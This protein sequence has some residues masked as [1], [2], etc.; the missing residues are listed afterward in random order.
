LE[1]HELTEMNETK[2]RDRPCVLVVDDFEELRDVVV[3]FAALYGIDSE[4]AENGQTA[5]EK[6]KNGSFD[7]VLMDL[8]M[9]VMDGFAALRW[10]REQNFTKPIIAITAHVSAEDQE[11]C[12]QAGFDGFLAKPF[13][14]GELE[15]IFRNCS[16]AFFQ[17]KGGAFLANVQAV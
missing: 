12:V 17:S 15:R 10:M 5:C 4:V 7:L 16:D 6:L 9:P 2:N 11:K 13:T 14:E 3:S 1:Q 8:Q